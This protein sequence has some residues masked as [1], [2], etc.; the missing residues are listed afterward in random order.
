MDVAGAR[1]TTY[2]GADSLHGYPEE[3]VDAADRHPWPTLGDV[4]T[5]RGC[6]RRPSWR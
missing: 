1:L 3:Y 6:G 4:L 5:E 2:L